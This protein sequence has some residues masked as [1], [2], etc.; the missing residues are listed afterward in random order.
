MKNLI[1]GLAA[2]II[3]ILLLLTLYTIQGKTERK[4]EIQ[5][6]ITTAMEAA[7]QKTK[8]EGNYTNNDEFQAAFIENLML[9]MDSDSDIS[10]TVL[11]ADYQKGF[12]L[13]K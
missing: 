1:T 7:G 4:T 12:F 3:V 8:E 5:D 11:K 6:G 9:Q 10:V 2:F 13:Q